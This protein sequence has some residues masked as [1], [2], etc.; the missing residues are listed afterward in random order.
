MRP[1]LCASA[2]RFALLSTCELCF[3]FQ[4]L[5]QP[6]DKDGSV[7]T[8]GS[9]VA[10]RRLRSLVPL[11]CLS[12][13][14]LDRQMERPGKIPGWGGGRDV[15]HTGRGGASGDRPITPGEAPG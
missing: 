4:T 2:Q 8:C 11:S 6:G 15:N 1:G 5:V 3:D 10:L 14:E 12:K 13:R 9:C 7:Q